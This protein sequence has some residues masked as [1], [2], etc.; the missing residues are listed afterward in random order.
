MQ[1]DLTSGQK[2]LI[3]RLS[4]AVRWSKRGRLLRIARSPLKVLQM[5]HLREAGKTR[6]LKARTFWGGQ[7]EIVFPERVS[8]F[9]WR[10]GYFEAD[11]CLFMTTFL[12]QGMCFVDIGS[13]FGFFTLLAAHLIEREGQIIAFEPSS[14]TYN[15][16]QKNIH[17]YCTCPNVHLWNCAAHSENGWAQFHDYGLEDS[18]FN[19]M[20]RSRDT[21][22]PCADGVKVR[23]QTRR[24]DDVLSA[25]QIAAVDMIKIDA[26]S[27]EMHALIGLERTL[28]VCRPKIIVEMG[29]FDVPGAPSSR[30][31]AQHLQQLHYRPFDVREGKIS[32]HTL[33]ETYE[34]TNLLFVHDDTR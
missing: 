22:K 12:R 29:D 23:V 9:I 32:P 8:E 34:Y 4:L 19:S 1:A 3:N 24:V 27:C 6:K 25:E 2:E 13:H 15:Q 14:G 17:L 16:L 20:F 11:V 18:A 28:Q 30:Q 10:Y 31:V 26:E 21:T 7:M 5:R 33:Q